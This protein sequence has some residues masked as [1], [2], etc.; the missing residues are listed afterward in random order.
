MRIAHSKLEDL[1]LPRLS[2]QRMVGRSGQPY[3]SVRE[4]GGPVVGKI[5]QAQYGPIEFKPDFVQQYP[6]L[7]EV[8]IVHT[9]NGQ[10]DYRW[11]YQCRD[12][13]YRHGLPRNCDLKLPFERLKTQLQQANWYDYHKLNLPHLTC[14]RRRHRDGRDYYA[15][16]I[17]AQ[18]AKTATE[19]IRAALTPAEQQAAQK[20]IKQLK[21]QAR[22]AKIRSQD[23][24]I[25]TMPTR[26]LA[27]DYRHDAWVSRFVEHEQYFLS[28]AYKL[29]DEVW[30]QMVQSEHW[31]QQALRF[32]DQAAHVLPQVPRTIGLVEGGQ[33][34]GRILFSASFVAAYPQMKELTVVHLPQG[35]FYA[36]LPLEGNCYEE[37]WAQS[38]VGRTPWP[39]PQ[40]TSYP[41]SWGIAYAI[42]YT[43]QDST[44]EMELGNLLYSNLDIKEGQIIYDSWLFKKLLVVPMSRFISMAC[45]QHELDDAQNNV[46]DWLHDDY[47]DPKF[48]HEI[49]LEPEGRPHVY[50]WLPG[51]DDQDLIQAATVAIAPPPPKTTYADF[52]E[53]KQDDAT[54]LIVLL[55]QK[56]GIF[57][58]LES[59]L[60]SK[61]TL[62]FI[63]LALEA[64]LTPFAGKTRWFELE[65]RAQPFF[66]RL[67]AHQYVLPEL[68]AFMRRP[69]AEALS[70][71][72]GHSATPTWALVLPTQG[73]PLGP[74]A[75][76]VTI[77]L[78]SAE[79]ITDSLSLPDGSA[80]L[81]RR[82]L[83]ERA[84]A[85]L[86]QKLTCLWYLP[87][88]IPMGASIAS[89]E[90]FAQKHYLSWLYHS[91]AAPEA[92]AVQLPAECSL[93]RK[94][95]QSA[96]KNGM[97]LLKSGRTS[98]KDSPD[99]RALDAWQQQH[100][101]ITTGRATALGSM[102]GP[103]A[104]Q[105]YYCYQITSPVTPRRKLGV[106]VL[107]DFKLKHTLVL[108]YL[109]LYRRLRR[110][111]NT[112]KVGTLVPAALRQALERA[113]IV[114][115][116]KREREP[117]YYLD[118]I[119]LLLNAYRHACAVVVT[120]QL[121]LSSKDLISL[122]RQG[123]VFSQAQYLEHRLAPSFGSEANEAGQELLT[124]LIAALLSG[125]N[126]RQEQALKGKWARDQ[127]GLNQCWGEVF[128]LLA[129]MATAYRRKVS[130][131]KQP[132]TMAEARTRILVLLGLVDPSERPEYFT[133]RKFNEF[134]AQSK[135]PDQP[136][137]QA[138]PAQQ[139]E[140]VPYAQQSTPAA[141]TKLAAQSKQVVPTD[142]EEQEPTDLR[143]TPL[144]K[145]QRPTPPKV[146]EWNEEVDPD[147][148]MADF[149]DG[150]ADDYD[151]LSDILS[152]L[153][154]DSF[155]DF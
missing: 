100:L 31:R 50:T 81:K 137:Q 144:N 104:I 8:V 63:E 138:Q 15:I 24:M 66:A 32:Q 92:L 68:S 20:Q 30:Q 48:Q 147:E 145:K 75:Q 44:P 97:V 131:A 21:A 61:D 91:L 58:R 25:A 19:L 5:A 143:A 155:D 84:Q 7:N 69:W 18:A 4:R 11:R 106:Y 129:L 72:R 128:D 57:P 46:P 127:V 28:V 90:H 139:T 148:F 10:Y 42:H 74:K 118:R 113:H 39:Q 9:K 125:L 38:K 2:L 114:F 78:G 116:D 27:F 94:A 43:M 23:L 45:R 34:T 133:V 93:H 98:K 51:R 122:Y 55:G 108:W 126:G 79:H 49:Y 146:D 88:P 105:G 37:E 59:A 117:N 103:D 102:L 64:L 89:T 35:Y 14:E 65:S 83:V 130:A 124:E 60:G 151:D 33:A 112:K 40:F 70:S 17:S 110:E 13:S 3:Y 76:R 12:G 1:G 36:H 120:N 77:I 135:L 123:R 140:P 71:F 29:E 101:K 99:A 150:F 52:I 86:K 152:G 85:Q 73:T 41:K 111:R 115:L 141:Q 142:Q 80:L 119:S 87:C 96:C 54:A 82:Q 121:K 149:D 154:D 62:V 153:G 22:Q 95:V 47:F 107:C 134:K 132:I 53:L 16:T 26:A 109:L 67:S 136:A 56:E 6:I